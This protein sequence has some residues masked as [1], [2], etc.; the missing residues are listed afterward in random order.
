MRGKRQLM[1]GIRRRT[2]AGAPW[3]DVPSRTDPEA[4]VAGQHGRAARAPGQTRSE[5]TRRTAPARTAP[6]VLVA[7]VNEW[8]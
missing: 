5:P 6:T 3:R 7:A 8:L 2:R 4:D 1:D